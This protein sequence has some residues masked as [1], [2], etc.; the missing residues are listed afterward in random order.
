MAINTSHAVVNLA[1][2]PIIGRWTPRK[3]RDVVASR[4]GLAERLARLIRQADDAPRVLI[5]ASAVGYYGDRGDEWLDESSA[6]GAGFL[7][8]LCEQWEQAALGLQSD[9]LRVAIPRIGVVLDRDGGALGQLL[10]VFRLGLGGRIGAG[11]QYLPFIHLDD[12]VDLIATALTDWRYKGVFNATAPEPVTNAELTALLSRAT[13]RP[14]IFHVPA[15]GLRLG[16]GEAASVLLGSQRARPGVALANGFVFRYPTAREALD[17]LLAGEA[18]VSV[19]PIAAPDTSHEYLAQ[20]PPVYELFVRTDLGAPIDQVAPFFSRPENLGLLTPSS[21][22]FRMTSSPVEIKAGSRIGYRLSVFGV[23]IRW[24]TLI[25]R[26]SENASF[27]DAQERGPYRSWWHEHSFEQSGPT[28]T[29]VD[30]VRYAPPLGVLGRAL[31]RLLIEDE[32]RRIFAYRNDV[33][34]RRFRNAPLS[35]ESRDDRQRPS[36]II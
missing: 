3:R 36:A 32:L 5:S 31:N 29:M 16:L 13:R 17:A 23:P 20:R 2:E 7:A 14:A 34:R 19:R 18:A 22:R 10:P 28:T 15:I 9:R 21:M 27:V 25:A 1:G 24:Q 35:Q 11:K 8:E 6:R 12:L 26:W 4:V 30:R 33:I